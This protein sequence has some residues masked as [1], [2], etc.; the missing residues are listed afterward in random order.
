MLVLKLFKDCKTNK[1]IVIVVVESGSDPIKPWVFSWTVCL[2]K[3]YIKI[4]IRI[5]II[6]TNIDSNYTKLKSF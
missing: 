1:S 5:D 6:N 4:I 3:N 2:I